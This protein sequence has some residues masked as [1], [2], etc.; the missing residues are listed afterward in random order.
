MARSMESCI[1]ECHARALERLPEGK[2][3]RWVDDGQEGGWFEYADPDEEQ[4]ES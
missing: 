1:S 2:V 3:L 4:E